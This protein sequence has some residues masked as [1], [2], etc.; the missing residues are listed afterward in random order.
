MGSDKSYGSPSFIISKKGRALP[1]LVVDSR[2]YNKYIESET[3]VF[4][5]S[6]LSVL[7]EKVSKSRFLSIIDLKSAYY[8]IRV[9]KETV[10]SG[11]NSFTT[12]FGTYAFLCLLTGGSYSPN[13]FTT[14]ILKHL[15]TSKDMSYNYLHD[16]IAH[17]D[18]LSLFSPKER[19]LAEHLQR[20]E[21][22]ISRISNMNLKISL[23]KSTLLVDLTKSSA[24]LL[25][26]TIFDGQ[27]SI[28]EK[29][30]SDL[31]NLP[32]PKNT[33]QAQSFIGS[34]V[35][36][37]ALLG[38]DCLMALN[39]ISKNILPTLNWNEDCERAFLLIKKRLTEDLC[40][41]F[42]ATD[43]VL[44]MFA[45]AS[46][47]GIGSAC[48]SIPLQALD[49]LKHDNPFKYPNP[50]NNLLMTRHSEI[51]NI[52]LRSVSVDMGV[53]ELIINIFKIYGEHRGQ[54]IRAARDLII[55]YSRVYA[56]DVLF[57][58]QGGCETNSDGTISYNFQKFDELLEL[59]AEGD[60]TSDITCN[61]ILTTLCYILERSVH[62]IFLSK[63]K[64]MK[65]RYTAISKT[66]SLLDP[67]WIAYNT[68]SESFCLLELFENWE[69]FKNSTENRKYEKDPKKIMTKILT[70]ISKKKSGLKDQVKVVGFNSKSL[71]P[72]QAKCSI[73]QNEAF[74]IWECLESFSDFFPGNIP[75]LLSDSL[76]VTQAIQSKTRFESYIKNE[77]ILAK[78]ALNYPQVPV[79][80]IKGTINLVD[81]LS[82]LTQENQL[83]QFFSKNPFNEENATFN[84]EFDQKCEAKLFSSLAA[85]FDTMFINKKQLDEKTTDQVNIL[86]ESLLDDLYMKYLNRDSF[87]ADYDEAELKLGKKEGFIETTTYI[88]ERESGKLL[89]PKNKYAICVAYEHSRNAHRGIAAL[90]SIMTSKYVCKYKNILKASIRNFSLACLG[91]MTGKK[92]NAKNLKGIIKA[93]R[94]ND[95]W[96]LDLIERP[97]ALNQ[98]IS[99]NY[100]KS[101]LVAT[102]VYSKCS[103]PFLIHGNKAFEVTNALF[104]LLALCGPFR[105]VHS[106]NGSIFRNRVV[107]KFCENSSIGLGSFSQ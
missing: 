21:I 10:D 81:F 16:V 37:R 47:N 13:I 89:L 96:Q 48:L 42:P 12:I 83:N 78:I 90:F 98:S 67:I 1:R 79:F 63:N 33:K 76:S 86:S 103:L 27:M 54:N 88:Y 58:I 3:S 101:V 72:A 2:N 49:L 59:I 52:P 9:S 44:L 61:L 56:P 7:K 107:S 36:Y 66:D 97:Q 31:K 45:D 23:E 99:S 4:M 82:R 39:V 75:I 22:L 73:F 80:H 40:I 104:T 60:A 25:G 57:K 77:N 105:A 85:Y 32:R 19:S 18:D 102:D 26:F 35:F 87:Y 92:N 94:P 17:Y 14:Y 95:I 53:W 65:T 8:G 34:L 62:L 24:D 93:K 68:D 100:A 64:I 71:N 70:E 55:N 91:C 106:D 15:H 41:K 69:G 11:I 50:V 74:A 5:Q 30:L 20:F 29:K 51:Y 28:P 38:K 46:K 6:I 84:M 43:E